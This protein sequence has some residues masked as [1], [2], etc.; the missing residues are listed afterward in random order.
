MKVDNLIL[1]EEMKIDIAQENLARCRAL[2]QKL[3]EKLKSSK[4]RSMR[5]YIPQWKVFGYV[6]KSKEYSLE[7]LDNDVL[8]LKTYF[9]D[10]FFYRW[11]TVY[12]T[13]DKIKVYEYL[14]S[15]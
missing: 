12:Y 11:T 10:E 5:F 8:E 1:K 14:L 4:V 3:V 9:D 7:L 15:E 2:Q 13:T 6:I